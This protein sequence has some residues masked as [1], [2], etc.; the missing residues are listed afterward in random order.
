MYVKQAYI[1]T[2]Q[3]AEKDFAEDGTII[4]QEYYQLRDRYL[5]EEDPMTR[6]RMLLDG[7]LSQHLREMALWAYNQEQI[8]TDE[9]AEKMGLCEDL[10]MS[11]PLKWAA[12]MNSAKAQ[13]QE[14]VR[15][16]ILR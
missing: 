15:A 3:E 6:N 12:C 10:K 5:W 2:K 8:L 16:E 9:I 11:D 1:V 7:T 4:G 13:A 14:T